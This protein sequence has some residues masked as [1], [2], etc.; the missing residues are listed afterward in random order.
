M[1]QLWGS[2]ADVWAGICGHTLWL[3]L[4]FSIAIVFFERRNPKS[5]WA[6]L[7][8]LYFIPVLG[9][10]LY[11][12]LGWNMHNRKM[13]RIKEVEEQLG[14]AIRRQTRQLKAASMENIDP[15]ISDYR[16]LIMYNLATSEAVLTDDNGVRIFVDGRSKFQAL[17]EDI[18]RAR[19]FIHIQYY[20]IRNDVL[21]GEIRKLL[22]QKAAE[23]VEVRVLFDAMGCR[24]VNHR[25]WKGLVHEGIRVAEFFP[26]FFGRLQLRMN[27]RNHR[28]IVVIDHQV[29]YVGG[30][31]IGREYVD[32]EE[33]YGHWRD[34]HLRITGSAVGALGLRF[35][36]DWNYA[37]GENLLES[38]GVW[39]AAEHM[40]EGPY[41]PEEKGGH[42]DIQIISSGPD[43]TTR[44][45]RDNYLQ[46]IH[47]ARESIYIQTP[48]FI[49]DE[50]I[51]TALKIA[52]RSGVRV[53]I[54]IPCKPDHMFVY[55]ATYS[56]VGELV[57]EGAN[58]Y[59]Y[60][61]G[62]LHSKG[63][64]V[65]GRVFCYGTANMDIRSFSLN[66]EV[67]AVVYDAHKAKEMEGYFQQ[68]LKHCTCITRD[69][70]AARGVAV[71]LREQICRLLS[72]LL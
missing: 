20:I 56:Y 67:N 46:L 16:E 29:A 10:I 35:A 42:C 4:L 24:G 3:S 70:Y 9:F 39:N 31:N 37:S 21:F 33:K 6:W 55:W 34:T 53:H 36:M 51:L 60:D 44:Q 13:F 52:V 65:D 18:R 63:I 11:L 26:A 27:Y 8:L 25:Y 59:T 69:M 1:E 64:I 22:V 54:M 38:P 19:H 66:F 61:N 58:C 71:R 14:Q 68:D 72:P 15:A 5:V 43:N 32:L 62:F 17:M 48:Y 57:M 45:I 7:L 40:L 12:F 30:F 23:G 50:E 2:V 47:K 28:K 49:P 41:I